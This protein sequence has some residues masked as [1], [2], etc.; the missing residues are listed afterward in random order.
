M[1][2]KKVGREKYYNVEHSKH[3][4]ILILEDNIMN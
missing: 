4:Y 1:V 2:T 3:I